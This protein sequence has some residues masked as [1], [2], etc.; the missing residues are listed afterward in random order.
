MPCGAINSIN[1]TSAIYAQITLA[2][3]QHIKVIHTPIRAPNANAYAERWVRSVRRECLDQ[4]FILN[5][6]H[7]H[8]VLREHVHITTT[9]DDHIKG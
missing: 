5:E 8:S 9:Q 7:L 4:L 6:R 3:T 1:V 2:A